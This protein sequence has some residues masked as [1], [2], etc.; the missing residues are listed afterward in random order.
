M[1]IPV[2]ACQSVGAGPPWKTKTGESKFDDQCSLDYDEHLTLIVPFDSGYDCTYLDLEALIEY[3]SPMFLAASAE[4]SIHEMGADK[5]LAQ[6][7]ISKLK[8]IVR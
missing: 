7:V 6:L 3:L 5:T 2:S 8:E 1:E 4:V